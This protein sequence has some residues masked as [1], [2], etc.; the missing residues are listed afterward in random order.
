MSEAG[1][2]SIAVAVIGGIVAYAVARLNKS[3]P[4]S[5][6][7]QQQITDLKTEIDKLNKR[8]RITDDY[9]YQLRQAVEDAGG[10]VPPWPKELTAP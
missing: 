3:R 9:V 6:V 7:T 8:S 10:V 2:V 5:E 1:I 4:K